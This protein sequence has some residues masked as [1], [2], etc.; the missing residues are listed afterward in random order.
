MGHFSE[1][2]EIRPAGIKVRQDSESE[3]QAAGHGT[4]TSPRSETPVAYSNELTLDGASDDVS[5]GH[6]PRFSSLCSSRHAPQEITSSPLHHALDENENSANDSPR[7]MNSQ[8]E[9]IAHVNRVQHIAAF[10]K[11][12]KTLNEVETA[13]INLW[14]AASFEQLEWNRHLEKTKYRREYQAG[15]SLIDRSLKMDEYQMKDVDGQNIDEAAAEAIVKLPKSRFRGC[16][17]A[18]VWIAMR[19]DGA[20]G[21]FV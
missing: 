11:P 17:L 16:S 4:D 2:S 5:P 13:A 21:A 6:T 14:K 1:H 12:G 9:W 8:G 20:P 19:N 3:P 10:F 15:D 7:S 18:D